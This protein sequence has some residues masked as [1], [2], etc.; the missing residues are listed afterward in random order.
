M[1]DILETFK[2]SKIKKLD[3]WF[4]S[5]ADVYTRL[6]NEKNIKLRVD[7]LEL[8]VNIEN[9]IMDIITESVFS[10]AI[11]QNGNLVVGNS[12]DKIT[13]SP[14]FYRMIVLPGISINSYTEKLLYESRDLDSSSVIGKLSSEYCFIVDKKPYYFYDELSYLK[15]NY[16][17]INSYI[18]S[19]ES[20]LVDF[21]EDDKWR[22]KI[23][24]YEI[25]DNA[26]E[27]GNKFSKDKLIMAKYVI[28]GDGFYFTISDQGK[29]FKANEVIMKSLDTFSS[30]GRGIHI[31]RN[32]SEFFF[33]SQNGKEISFHVKRKYAVVLPKFF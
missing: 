4:S 32:L 9:G 17:C 7:N 22:I 31:V 12:K 13:I 5:N 2:N 28:L 20:K 8:L 15:T 3:Y 30:T 19:I 16:D 27:H 21:S 33:I 26:V 23:L 29:G 14:D 6:I 10:F 18:N 1:T 24:L 25:F 11:L